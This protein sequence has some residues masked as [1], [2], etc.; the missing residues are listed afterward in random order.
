MFSE[1]HCAHTICHK[2]YPIAQSWLNTLSKLQLVK[3]LEE[4]Q[5]WR[6]YACFNSK[7]SHE[8]LLSNLTSP[9]A[10]SIRYLTLWLSIEA[11]NDFSF[12]MKYA[13]ALCFSTTLLNGVKSC[14]ST[15]WQ[16]L[17]NLSAA[18]VS[19]IKS[20]PSSFLVIQF[21]KFFV[22]IKDLCILLLL[23]V[24]KTN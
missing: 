11:S 15:N 18:N 16:I 6:I 12:I 7:A 2:N 5:R 13:S 17:I 21:F 24:L 20:S 8:D 1:H 22:G 19:I 9:H 23:Q 14:H 10:S 4:A 3:G